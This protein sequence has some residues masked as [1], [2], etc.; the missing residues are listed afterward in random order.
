[1]GP[2]AVQLS[3]LAGFFWCVNCPAL[4]QDP[5]ACWDTFETHHLQAGSR[6][7]EWIG[8]EWAS[9]LYKHRLLVN[10]GALIREKFVLASFFSR[11]LVSFSAQPAFQEY[12]VHVGRGRLTTTR[13]GWFSGLWYYSLFWTLILLKMYAAINFFYYVLSQIMS[14]HLLFSCSLGLTSIIFFP[15]LQWKIYRFWNLLYFWSKL[16]IFWGSGHYIILCLYLHLL[17][18]IFI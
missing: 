15:F 5:A 2:P 17:K 3:D 7:Q 11:R 12:A 1:V 10:F 8:R 4:L 14:F 9:P 16:C 13:N 18:T 6:H